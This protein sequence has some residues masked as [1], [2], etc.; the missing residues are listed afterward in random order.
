MNTNLS[1]WRISWYIS[2]SFQYISEEEY[3]HISPWRISW[4]TSLSFQSMSEWDYTHRSLQDL[5]VYASGGIYQPASQHVTATSAMA[6]TD[7]HWHLTK[8]Y[9]KPKDSIDKLTKPC[10]LTKKNK[11]TN[12][13]SRIQPW[14]LGWLDSTCRIVFFGFFIK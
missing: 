14:S 3:T 4:S 1:R 12:P 5:L 7:F 9:I 13:A 2:L 10:Y 8:M 6:F 11:K